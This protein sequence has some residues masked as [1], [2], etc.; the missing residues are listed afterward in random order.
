MHDQ[1]LD[2]REK[3]VVMRPIS[4]PSTDKRDPIGAVRVEVDELMTDEEILQ[5]R[6][7]S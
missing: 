4:V 3:M 6:V 1:W 5:E 2:L 7:V